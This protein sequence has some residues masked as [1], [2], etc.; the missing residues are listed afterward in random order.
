MEM[1]PVASLKSAATK[2]AAPL[3]VPSAA[4]LAMEMVLAVLDSGPRNERTFS[5]LL[6]V[7]QSVEVRSPGCPEVAFW[8]LV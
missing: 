3:V 8:A 4:A 7:D 2:L 6:K 5:L 1:L